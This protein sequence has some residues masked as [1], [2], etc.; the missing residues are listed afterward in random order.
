MRTT[1][2]LNT[3]AQPVN[4]LPLSTVSW[5]E[6]IRYMVLDRARVLEYYEDWEVHSQ[7]WTT[8]VPAVMMLV[9]RQKTKTG[10]R[11]SKGNLFL[12]DGYRCQYCGIGVDRRTATVDHVLPVS[13]G[14]RTTFENTVTACGVCNANKGNN[15]RIVPK[16]QPV[17]PTYWQLVSSRQSMGWP[18][19]APQWLPYLG[20]GY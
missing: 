15:R 17:K 5:Q 6:A 2:L 10:V 4:W 19:A 3:D 9:E 11:F 13:H 1:L 8:R 12:R 18:D 16:T 20:Q 14:G 7:N